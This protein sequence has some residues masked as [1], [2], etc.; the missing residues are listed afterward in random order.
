[1]AVSRLES[2]EPQKNVASYA[3]EISRA[4]ETLKSILKNSKN[5]QLIEYIKSIAELRIKGQDYFEQEIKRYSTSIKAESQQIVS[6][7]V[8]RKINLCLYRSSREFAETTQETC[9]RILKE[10]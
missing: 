2:L 4:K 6:D 9:K 1:M 7:E 10:F 8:I 3:Q 5:K